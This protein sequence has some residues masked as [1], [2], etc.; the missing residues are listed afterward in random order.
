[1]RKQLFVSSM[2]SLR[3]NKYRHMKLFKYIAILIWRLWFYC[4]V[5]GTVL[6]AFPLLLITTYKESWYS[7]FYKIA[8][9][10]GKTLLFVM[11]FKAKIV[12]EQQKVKSDKSYMFIANHT[13]MIDIMLMLAIVKKP[14]VFVGK[15]ELRR[16]PF[17]GLI[18]KRSSILVNRSDAESRKCVFT[19]AQRRLNEGMSICIF[20]EGLVPVDE[21][22]V[23]SEFK[24]G[25]FALAIDHQIPIVPM[26]FYDCKKRLSYTFFSGSPG[27]LRV[28]IHEFLETKGLKVRDK[29]AIKEKAFKIIHAE[30][31]NDSK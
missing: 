26:T 12:S 21:S 15:S 13:S 24:N 17:F 18:F 1:M 23:L 30:L 20:P 16:I 28:K 14:L 8:H 4:W 6:F 7:S 25:A 3:N 9:A 10:W 19:E 22:V 27:D 31:I 11:G 5:I 2:L 29:R